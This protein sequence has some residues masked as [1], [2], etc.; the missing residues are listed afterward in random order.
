MKRISVED[1]LG[2]TK[3]VVDESKSHIIIDKDYLDKEE[4]KPK[5]KPTVVTKPKTEKKAA[6]PTTTTT[7]ET[8][9][10]IVKEEETPKATTKRVDK[11]KAIKRKAKQVKKKTDATKDEKVK[12]A[13]EEKNQKIKIK[14]IGN[15]SE[16]EN[17]ENS[18]T[19]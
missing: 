12:K 7:T 5:V 3:F 8:T 9:T 19:N 11:T 18:P 15:K 17:P 1:K 10:V 13:L 6:Q 4:A 16:L 2:K 14:K